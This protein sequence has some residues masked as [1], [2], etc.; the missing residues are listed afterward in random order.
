MADTTTSSNGHAAG[1]RHSVTHA[2]DTSRGTAVRGLKHTAS[3]LRG[4]DVLHRTSTLGSMA[5]HTAGRLDAAAQYLEGYDAERVLGD[6]RAAVTR[7]P[8]RSLAI[9]AT[10]G[11][12]VAAAWKRHD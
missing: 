12:M 11:F 2:I 9:A 4:N 10:F 1:L 6:V 3:A 8:A 5:E 7:N